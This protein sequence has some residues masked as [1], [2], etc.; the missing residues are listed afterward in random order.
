MAALS[1][2]K[3]DRV[4]DLVMD[5]YRRHLAD[6]DGLPT[7]GRFLFYECE[8]EGNAA[9]PSPT[10]TRPN[11]RR[12]IGWPPGSQDITDGLTRLRTAGLIPWDHIAD[13][14]RSLLIWQHAPTVLDYVLER[15][16]HATINPW[17]DEP[18]PLVLTESNGMA[19]VLRRVASQHC[20]PIGGTKGMTRGWLL[21]KVVPLLEQTGSRTV[22]YLGDLDKPGLDI[23][24][25]S[26]RVIEAA[27]GEDL[28]WTRIGIL[29]DQTTGMT[30]I[31]KFD[32]RTKVISPGYEVEALGQAAVVAL[33]RDAL[34]SL[35]PEPLTS[36]HER[37]EAERQELR[38]RLA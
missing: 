2:T 24:R 34:T 27:L 12:S 29:P 10:D 20:C 6:P 31:D 3:K 37:E 22:L 17:G 14:E 15:L 35:L 18:P 28:D 30:P 16:D 23:E 32:G 33:V 38:E 1:A 7:T 21:T 8:Q 25:N 19:Q 9:K 13:T 4:E 26:R 5:H 36:V 11:R